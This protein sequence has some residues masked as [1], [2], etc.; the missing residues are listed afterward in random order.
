M[1]ACKETGG[2]DETNT[3]SV[4]GCVVSAASA[5]IDASITRPAAIARLNGRRGG[6]GG[7][8]GGALLDTT[9]TS[10]CCASGASICALALFF[11]GA[12]SRSTS[13]M[14]TRRKRTFWPFFFLCDAFFVS[15]VSASA[16]SSMSSARGKSSSRLTLALESLEMRSASAACMASAGAVRREVRCCIRSPSSVRAST[17]LNKFAF[18]ITLDPLPKPPVSLSPR[19]LTPHQ[20]AIQ[21]HVS[22]L[23][24]PRLPTQSY[25]SLALNTWSLAP[26]YPSP[27]SEQWIEI[28]SRR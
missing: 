14:P 12:S 9:T 11:G 28:R 18:A 19:V 7:T 10:G 20:Q 4:L 25:N 16:T 2:G 21:A 27:G 13:S 1:A 6:G 17:S 5:P 8:S 26:P 3:L 22:H 15:A 23:S 24:R